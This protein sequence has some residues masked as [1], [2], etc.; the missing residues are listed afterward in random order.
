MYQAMDLKVR[1]RP[2]DSCQLET[3]PQKAMISMLILGLSRPLL[4][5]NLILT[6]TGELIFDRRGRIESPT[7]AAEVRAPIPPHTASFLRSH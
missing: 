2:C 1:C 3:C 7:C 5:M 6:L 4:G